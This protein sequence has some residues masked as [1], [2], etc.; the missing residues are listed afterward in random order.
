MHRVVEGRDKLDHWL[1]Q[2]QRMMKQPQEY[3]QRT[4]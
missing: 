1:V 2:C 4:V 3:V